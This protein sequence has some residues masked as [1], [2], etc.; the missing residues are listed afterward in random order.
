MINAEKVKRD[1]LSRYNEQRELDNQ[2]TTPFMSRQVRALADVLVGEINKE[3]KNFVENS[4]K[5]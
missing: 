5:L 4:R 1:V 2:P 3:L